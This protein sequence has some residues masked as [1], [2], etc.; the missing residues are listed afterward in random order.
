MSESKKKNEK[1]SQ[2]T[3]EKDFNFKVNLNQEDLDFVLKRFNSAE[4][5][6]Q[7]M[8]DRLKRER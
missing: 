5:A 8:V 4:F 2:K 3:E 6:L 7:Y 1:K